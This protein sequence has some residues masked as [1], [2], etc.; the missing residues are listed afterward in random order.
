MT[1]KEHLEAVLVKVEETYWGKFS[2]RSRTH[3]GTHDYEYCAMG[4]LELTGDNHSYRSTWPIETKYPEEVRL[5][6]LTSGISGGTHCSRVVNK[7]DSARDRQSIINWL[8]RAIAK[9]EKEEK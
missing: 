4:L 9:A 8:K 7:N 3:G 2:L 1:P 6:A 5:L